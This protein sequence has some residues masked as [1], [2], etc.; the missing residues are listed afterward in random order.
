LG[1]TRSGN[2]GVGL[3]AK[4]AGSLHANLHSIFGNF[5]SEKITK[6]SHVEKLCLI[7]SGVRPR[8]D[9]RLH[10]PADP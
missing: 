8:P 1:F 5:G 9:Q 7:D 10:D 6:A 4:S 3:G 2:R